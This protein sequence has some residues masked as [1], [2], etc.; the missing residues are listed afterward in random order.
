[1]SVHSKFASPYRFSSEREDHP[2]SRAASIHDWSLLPS[3][4]G[5]PGFS[6]G[7]T[8]APCFSS[9]NPAGRIESH[10]GSLPAHESR[11]SHSGDLSSFPFAPTTFKNAHL[12]PSASASDYRPDVNDFLNL[13]AEN[14]ELK[15]DIQD[16]QGRLAAPLCVLVPLILLYTLL[17]KP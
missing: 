13:R 17:T 3:Q 10:T 1:M 8:N 5:L 16:L 11:A 2:S 15:H 7:E 12:R 9:S 4:R 6:E 14:E